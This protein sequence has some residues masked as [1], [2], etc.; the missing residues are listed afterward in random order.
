MTPRVVITG[1]GVVCAA[2][3]E[4]E[5]VW[6]A[7]CGGRTAV[8]PV[9]RWNL[10]GQAAPP[11]G[12][13]AD[14][15]PRALVAD[16]K[17]HKLLRRSDV[18]GLYAA[19]RAIDAAGV[20]PHRAGLDVSAA[21]GFDDRTGV[22]VGSGGGSFQNQYDF[23]PLLTEAHGELHGFGAALT[24]TVNP[25]WLLRTLP[26]N[27]L[28]HVGI[29]Y[30]FKGPNACVTNHSVGGMLAIAEAAAAIRAGEADRA[31][32]IG[33]DAPVEPET[34]RYYER[35]GLLSADALRPF[36]AA[37]TGTV[38]GEGAGACVM[39]SEAAAAERGAAALGEVL[40]GACTNEAQGL[41][42]IRDDGEGLERAIVLGLEDAGLRA[43]D[44]GLIVAHGN[45]TRRS[46]VSEAAAIGRVFGPDPPPTTAFKWAFG[47]LLAASGV[48]DT[49]LAVL[50]LRRGVVPG[51]ATLREADAECAPLRVS[52]AAQRARGEVA[53]VLGRGFAGTNAVLVVRAAGPSGGG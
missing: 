16:R 32:A 36:D 40:G 43:A 44:V 13:V 7:V 21:A 10:S 2:G 52:S 3:G 22:Y 18:L 33:H 1:T 23:F 8:A 6:D 28:C 37:R 24:A 31:V 49:V 45:G 26:N 47:H 48:I 39:E 5:A 17:I 46:D 19:G 34:V 51:I 50:A 11:A 38:L 20:L 12:E 42:G 35:L 4:P 30:G 14:A 53:L 15:D 29:Q 41:L 27:V 25:M 9:R